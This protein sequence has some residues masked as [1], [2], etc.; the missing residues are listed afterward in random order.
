MLRKIPQSLDRFSKLD[1][2]HHNTEEC[3]S[4]NG[5]RLKDLVET[6]PKT[7]RLVG[8]CVQ[9]RLLRSN[10]DLKIGRG[11]VVSCVVYVR[12]FVC[13]FDQSGIGLAFT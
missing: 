4:G 13:E 9:T 5:R 7:S 6:C 1:S 11:D 2:L 8:Y 10:R 3:Q 12:A